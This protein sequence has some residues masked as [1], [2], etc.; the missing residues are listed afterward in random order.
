MRK[1]ILSL[2][3]VVLV[4]I[5]LLGWSISQIA[6]E[7]SDGPNLNERIA[8]LQLL[9]VD[10][11]RSLDTDSPRLQLYL[12]R[13]NSVNS[14][15]L[16]I[17]E[18]E[19][20]PLPEPLSSEFKKDAYLMLESD[21]GISLH[22]LMPETQKV[23]NITTSLHS[24]DSPYISRNTLFTLLFYIGLVAILLIWVA[25][26]IKQLLNLS[27]TTHD[28]GLGR[29]EKRIPVSKSSY[30]FNIESEF[31]RMADRIAQLVDDNKLLSRAVSHD[32]KTPIARLRFG[33]EAL[34]ETQNPELQ[35]KYFAR[36]NRDL[37]NMEELVSTLLS[38]ARLD[39]ANI[40]PNLEQIEL[41]AWVKS[42]LEAFGQTELDID[43]VPSSAPVLVE[44]DPIYLAMQLGN[45]LSNAERFG[46]S[47]IRVSLA[48]DDKHV[49]IV[50]E[51]DGEG[52]KQSEVEKV[53]QPFVRGSQ[54]RGNSGHGM[55]LAIVNRIGT[56]MDSKLSI[57]SSPSLGGACMRLKMK[58]LKSDES[59]MH[60][61]K[62]RNSR[63]ELESKKM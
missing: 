33:I 48:S 11:S 51:D 38:Y 1:L 12:K 55:G 20:F 59:P 19:R 46:K 3:F 57:H 52:I 18:L 29:L 17:A 34:E 28:F 54:S 37:D 53:I 32:L 41:N 9:G 14:E 30:I 50:V 4:S 62:R 26:L 43:F 31:N 16:S 63:C 13:W 10:L 15:K 25:P 2:V 56:W 27:K 58:R 6:S 21:E 40:Q 49:V 47:K 23:L 35:A 39:E 7:P 60:D 22:F 42:R 24:I 5:A 8:A 61:V 44:S 36:L 45:L